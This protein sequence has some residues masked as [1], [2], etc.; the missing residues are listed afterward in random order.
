MEYDLALKILIHATTWMHLEN[1]MLSETGQSQKAKYCMIPQIQVP[2][3]IKFKETEQSGGSQGPMRQ[4][5]ADLLLF[6]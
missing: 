3:I 5:N 1:I 2:G 4:G 6:Q